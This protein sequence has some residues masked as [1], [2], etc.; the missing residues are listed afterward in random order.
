MVAQGSRR[1][2]FGLDII[3]ES[4]NRSNGAKI[5]GNLTEKHFKHQESLMGL[6]TSDESES[7]FLLQQLEKIQGYVQI[8]VGVIYIH[9]VS[10]LRQVGKSMV[11]LKSSSKEVI[12][13]YNVRYRVGE[14]HCMYLRAH[15]IRIKKD[16]RNYTDRALNRA[17]KNNDFGNNFHN[18][19]R[20]R[21]NYQAQLKI[22]FVP[23]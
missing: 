7:R 6:D 5:H 16:N 10:T 21:T 13:H 8:S 9:P 1:F 22:S 2:T 20:P 4:K 15:R 23:K 19:I 14:I 3:D 18:C 17:T 12:D 11:P